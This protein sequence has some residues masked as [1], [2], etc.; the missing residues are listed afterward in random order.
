MSMMIDVHDGLLQVLSAVEPSP[1][2]QHVREPGV[3]KTPR[4]TPRGQGEIVL[5]D[6]RCDDVVKRREDRL[7]FLMQARGSEPRITCMLGP[8]AY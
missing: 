2:K 8:V 1:K 3:Q 5:V 4:T 7:S 6:A